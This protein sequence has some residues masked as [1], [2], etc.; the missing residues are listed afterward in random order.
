MKTYTARIL[1]GMNYH[2]RVIEAL[3][4]ESAIQT[5]TD[6]LLPGEMLIQVKGAIKHSKLPKAIMRLFIVPRTNSKRLPSV[7]SSVEKLNRAP[8]E[9]IEFGDF[10]TFVNRVSIRN[11]P[12][13]PKTANSTCGAPLTMFSPFCFPRL[14]CGHFRK[15]VL[16][17]FY[18]P[19]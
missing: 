19:G 11:V 15:F 6:D 12:F 13:S 9:D 10:G 4:L 7:D 17:N 18:Y 3:S 5:L 16:S 8:P 1:I 14:Q 2:Y